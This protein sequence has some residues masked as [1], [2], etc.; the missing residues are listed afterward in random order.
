MLNQRRLLCVCLKIDRGLSSTWRA[1]LCDQHIWHI[2][3]WL[4]KVVLQ[5]QGCFQ[6]LFRLELIE[7]QILSACCC[8]RCKICTLPVGTFLKD[9][10]T[11]KRL[12]PLLL[13]GLTLWQARLSGGQVPIGSLM[14]ICIHK[15]WR[16][17]WQCWNFF[18]WSACVVVCRRSTTFK[19]LFPLMLIPLSLLHACRQASIGRTCKRPVFG[20]GHL[21]WR[22]GRQGSGSFCW[23]ARVFLKGG[24]TFHI[25]FVL[26][27]IELWMLHV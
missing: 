27:F 15:C 16:A 19:G 6:R 8:Q 11:F 23:P 20:L 12:L 17:H 4:V 1:C 18:C 10:G 25:V 2:L 3:S 5:G 14:F 26:N 13:I 7:L 9:A 21:C 22:A 24:S